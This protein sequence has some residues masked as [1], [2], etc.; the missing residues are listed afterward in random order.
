MRSIMMIGLI[1]LITGLPV[2]SFAQDCGPFCPVCSGTGSSTGAL[3]V[4]GVIIPGFL[5]IPGG[6]EERGVITV[7]G[8]I[9][10][11]LDAGIG[12]ALDS[13]KVLWSIRLE[14]IKEDESS[15]RPDLVLGTG[16]VQTGKS[17]QSL[18]VQ[19]SKSW[20]LSEV[21]AIRFSTGIAGLLP[22]VD[23]LYGLASLTLTITERW[24]P[25]ISYDGISLHPGIS[26]IPTDWLR[27]AFILMESEEP[28][29][30]IGFR[31]DFSKDN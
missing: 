14:A 22:E 6:E 18:F 11:W 10:S 12:Y 17:D 13:K 31:L 24:S 2:L 26:W 4:P 21:F 7:R 28:A 23:K 20:E 5:Y 25:F 3:V 16:S 8:G 9:T 30:S 19:L 1:L 29:V 15:L 27:L